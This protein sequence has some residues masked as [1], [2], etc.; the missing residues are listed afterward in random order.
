MASAAAVPLEK[1]ESVIEDLVSKGRLRVPPY[2]AVADRI[3]ETLGRRDA[4]LAEVA[5]LVGPDAVLAA[6]IPRCASSA[7]YRRD[8]TVTN[9]L[10]PSGRRRWARSSRSG[11]SSGSRGSRAST[12]WGSRS[13]PP[14]SASSRKTPRSSPPSRPLPRPPSWGR[15]GWPSRRPRCA[16]PGLPLT[17]G[18]SIAVARRPRLHRARAVSPEGLALAGEEPLPENR[19]PEAKIYTEEPFALWVLTPMCR[20][21]AR[22]FD[23]E[24]QPFALTGGLREQWEKLVALGPAGA[25]EGT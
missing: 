24:V 16:V 20:R 1:L 18:V 25:R 17:L 15:P 23:L 7:L 12:A 14:W 9:L 22:G 13:E 21:T 4:G 8:P 3:Q 5:H 11:A 6:A 2:P 19:L 10:A